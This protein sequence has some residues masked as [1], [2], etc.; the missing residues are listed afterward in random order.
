MK[1]RTT[2]LFTHVDSRDKKYIQ[3]CK[4]KGKTKGSKLSQTC[5]NYIVIFGRWES[6]IQN[7]GG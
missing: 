1:K 2:R 5:E 7:S 4:L 6:G 3:I